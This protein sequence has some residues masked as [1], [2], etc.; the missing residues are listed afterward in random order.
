MPKRVL[1][2]DDSPSVRDA[3]CRILE[4]QLGVEVCAVTANGLEAIEKALALRPDVIVLDLKMPGISGVEVAGILRK[5]LP[6]AKT[7]LFTLY[8]ESIS[9]STSSVLGMPVISKSDGIAKLVETVRSF[10]ASSKKQSL[11]SESG[12]A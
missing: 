3:I 12:A 8:G 9:G 5:E 4:K 6:S 1:I 7:I 2:A 10:L 11:I